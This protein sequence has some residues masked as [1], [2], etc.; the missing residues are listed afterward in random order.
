MHFLI[1]N[2]LISISERDEINTPVNC[3]H[4]WCRVGQFPQILGET[5]ESR[6]LASIIREVEMGKRKGAQNK[7]LQC[8]S[9][10]REK[11]TPIAMEN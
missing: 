2:S 7:F 1:G 11:S 3:L 9:Y 10:P 4:C 5:L 8:G 6:V